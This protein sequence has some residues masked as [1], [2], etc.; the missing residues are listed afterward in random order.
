MRHPE[1][2]DAEVSHRD[3]EIVVRVH[4]GFAQGEANHR[5][6]FTRREGIMQSMAE[7][8]TTDCNDQLGKLV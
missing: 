7:L 2:V 8:G 1:V 5:D 4:L 3:E 6:A